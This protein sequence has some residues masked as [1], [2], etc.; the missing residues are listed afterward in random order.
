LQALSRRFGSHSRLVTLQGAGGIGKTRLAI[1]YGWSS[2]DSWPGGVWFCDLS[3]ARNIEGIAA[4][5]GEGIG[6]PLGAGDA[7]AQLGHAIASR[8]QCLVILDNFEQ[9]VEHAADTVWSW[10]A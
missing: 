10:S 8:G 9:V 2:L 3:K 4:A 7:M 1:R 5:V 6:V